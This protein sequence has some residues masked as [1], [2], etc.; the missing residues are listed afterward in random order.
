MSAD[1][2]I[3]KRLKAGERI[4]VS[5]KNGCCIPMFHRRPDAYRCTLGKKRIDSA[6]VRR[7]MDS[8]IIVCANHGWYSEGHFVLNRDLRDERGRFKPRAKGASA[9]G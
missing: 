7:L 5:A 6:K 2:W 8:R 9:K 3:A 4:I 1:H